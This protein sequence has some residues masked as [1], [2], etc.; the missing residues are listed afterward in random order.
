M[1]ENEE[2][3]DF[4]VCLRLRPNLEGE[5]DAQAFALATETGGQPVLRVEAAR[6]QAQ[7]LADQVLFKQDS[8]EPIYSEFG[9]GF[10]RRAVLG[11][12]S[13]IFTYGQTNSGKT[14]T[15]S[16]LCQRLFSDLPGLIGSG[17]ADVVIE[18][19]VSELLGNMVRDLRTG[20]KAS[21]LEDVSGRVKC[22][23]IWT[24]LAA[25]ECADFAATA[26]ASRQTSSTYKNDA[27][28]RSHFVLQVRFT[29]RQTPNA[30]PGLLTLVDLA[31]S[32]RASRDALNHNEQQRKESID[33]NKSLMCLK[34]CIVKRSGSTG[35]THIPYRASKLT[36]LLKDAFELTT[37]KACSTLMIA[38]LSPGVDDLSATRNTLRYAS[39][40]FKAPG[41]APVQLDTS[42]PLNWDRVSVL[43]WLASVLGSAA[44]PESV[45][46][47]ENG[48]ALSALPEAE[49]IR[50][51]E[52]A[53]A[54]K[55][56]PKRA[57][58]IYLDL[59]G[60]II[61][62]RTRFKKAEQKR[63]KALAAEKKKRDR[64]FEEELARTG[65]VDLFRNKVPNE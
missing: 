54:G 25:T 23:S 9:R 28:S 8:V 61:D 34:E 27:S 21:V 59:W 18:A 11:G 49:F 5:A 14:Y 60:R 37:P 19:S 33:I 55:L 1:N 40:L 16:R 35:S 64:E 12:W 20:Q 56:G 15:L 46:P 58:A 36:L 50:R 10:L 29:P 2:F 26:L 42:N 17:N 3:K 51:C 13:T 44:N 39:E 24:P 38:C 41:K 32:E 57:K 52:S 53:S 22:S 45:C 62:A 43:R 47:R 30:E 31:G 65:S 4:V 6:V 48:R 63:W 7:F